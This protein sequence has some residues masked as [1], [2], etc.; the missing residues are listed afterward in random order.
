MATKLI[1]LPYN[2][3]LILK[4]GMDEKAQSS[5]VADMETRQ[6]VLDM[7]TKRQQTKVQ[8]ILDYILSLD[9]FQLTKSGHLLLNGKETFIHIS[10]LIS[11]MISVFKLDIPSGYEK[12]YEIFHKHKIPNKLLPNKYRRTQQNETKGSNKISHKLKWVKF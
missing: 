5:N 4:Q 12:L 2:R 10:D 6:K 9:E 11:D 1:L 8:T 7:F 3:Y